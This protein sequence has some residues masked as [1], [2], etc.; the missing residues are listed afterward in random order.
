MIKNYYNH[1]NSH[2]CTMPPRMNFGNQDYEFNLQR[3]EPESEDEDYDENND[4][5][6]DDESVDEY[7]PA[8]S[9]KCYLALCELYNGKIH[10][11]NNYF[12]NSQYLVIQRFSGNEIL[13]RML[14]DIVKQYSQVY[15]RLA[16]QSN[17]SHSIIK[18]YKNIIAREDYISPQIVK[19]SYLPDGECVAVI[20]TMWIKLIQR[21]WRTVFNERR[22]IIGERSRISSIFYREIHGTWPTGLNVVPSICGMLSQ[23][24]G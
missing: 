11:S 15:R 10:G 23:I 24:Q 1:L 7:L 9:G 19:C 17:I 4:F 13:S 20:K 6:E 14:N 5:Y 8:D 18:N 2:I 22:R 16:Q 12:I 3:Q 21:R